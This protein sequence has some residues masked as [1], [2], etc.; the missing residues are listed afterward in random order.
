MEAMTGLDVHQ[1]SDAGWNLL[2]NMQ[3]PSTFFQQTFGLE[4][5]MNRVSK[6]LQLSDTPHPDTLGDPLTHPTFQKDL[7]ECTLEIVT[8]PFDDIDTL[9]QTLT[10]FKAAAQQNTLDE[11]LWPISSP[12]PFSP[13]D[14]NRVSHLGNSATGIK[15]RD[16]YLQLAR[17]HP[18][19]R[20]A[21]TGIHVNVSLSETFWEE[22]RL[23]RNPTAV[24]DIFRTEGYM[25]LVR[26]LYR[27]KPLMIYL[28]GC[29]P[30][31]P[32]LQSE[33]AGQTDHLDTDQ[34]VS[35]RTSTY[36]FWQ[37]DAYWQL[38]LND[39]QSFTTQLGQTIA[40]GK[41]QSDGIQAFGEVY[42]FIRK[43][44]VRPGL[45][46]LTAQK[47]HGIDY[48]ELR[49]IDLNPFAPAGLSREQLRLIEI[50]MLYSALQPSPD[51]NQ[52]EKQQWRNNIERVSLAG[53]HGN[54][55]IHA[56]EHIQP[57]REWAGTLFEELTEYAQ[58]M[59]DCTGN[60][61]YT[62]VVQYF[63]EQVA[64]SQL[65]L[66]NKL[67]TNIKKDNCWKKSITDLM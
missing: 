48:I 9:L 18:L 53:R 58:W 43:R 31:L 12:P 3:F 15:K 6:A 14:E 33:Y 67:C 50:M 62:E 39:A 11:H 57:F 25:A 35:L 8:D 42:S 1:R 22:L 59:T 45:D 46:P 47:L 61:D 34:I 29:A 28:F 5:E 54:I 65:T 2:K 10:T 38:N 27:I 41:R 51:A 49:A 40:E 13:L 16:Y 37:C 30:M 63:S 44:A 21:F 4:L 36:G 24:P 66:V 26:N 17:K 64:N 19:W 52:K 32:H 20:A 55:D 60:S 56:G 23:L 7:L